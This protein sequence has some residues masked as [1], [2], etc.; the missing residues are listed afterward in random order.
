MELA[1]QT[2]RLEPA[3]VNIDTDGGM[4]LA[5]SLGILDE[6]RSRGVLE[7]LRAVSWSLPR[8]WRDRPSSSRHPL[9]RR[10]QRKIDGAPRDVDGGRIV[11]RVAALEAR[12]PVDEGQGAADGRRGLLRP[13]RRG[14]AE[15]TRARRCLT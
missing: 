9:R 5:E 4:A 6:G 15:V 1:S 14:R 8:A 3:R 7:S 12:L 10:L 13:G 11:P 2:T